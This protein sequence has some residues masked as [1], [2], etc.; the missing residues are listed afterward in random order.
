MPKNGVLQSDS[1]VDFN[2][3]FLLSSC[4]LNLF[5]KLREPFKKQIKLHLRDTWLICFYASDSKVCLC[6]RPAARIFV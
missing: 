2:I 4:F 6:K 1:F 3:V 5:F